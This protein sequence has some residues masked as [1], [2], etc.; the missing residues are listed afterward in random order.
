MDCFYNASLMKTGRRDIK[1]FALV[2][3]GPN[4]MIYGLI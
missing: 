4:V 2:D 3:L 1:V